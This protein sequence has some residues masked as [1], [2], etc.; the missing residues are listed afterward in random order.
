MDEPVWMV[1]GKI[2]LDEELTGLKKTSRAQ[3]SSLE[4]GLENYQLEVELFTIAFLMS[5]YKNGKHTSLDLDKVI[6]EYVELCQMLG[7]T[8]MLEEQLEDEVR[9]ICP[10]D[11]DGQA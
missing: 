6:A 1:S 3:I 9:G 11:D 2:S 4:D 5:E 10:S 8:N 7:I